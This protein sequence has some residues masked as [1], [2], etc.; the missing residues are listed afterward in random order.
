MTVKDI[1]NQFEDFDNDNNVISM[2]FPS[3]SLKKM[4]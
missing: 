3:N 4:I 1:K 2:S